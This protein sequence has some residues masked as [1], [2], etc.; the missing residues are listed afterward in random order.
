MKASSARR[1]PS[2]GK[3]IFC[4][5]YEY[6]RVALREC[7]CPKRCS[8]SLL[9]L[10]ISVETLRIPQSQKRDE[11]RVEDIRRFQ[12]RAVTDV[13]DQLELCTGNGLGDVFRLSRIRR[14][15]L[16]ATDHQRLRLDVLPVV[17]HGFGG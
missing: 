8:P 11:L 7:F 1:S 15:V 2:A 16:R 4:V 6:W 5:I 13:V 14:R 12:V 3:R 17:D 9:S 10:K